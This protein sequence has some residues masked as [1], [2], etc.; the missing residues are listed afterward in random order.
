M[1][2]DPERIEDLLDFKKIEEAVKEHWEAIGLREL[3]H[4]E[5]SKNSPTGYVEGPPTLNGEPHLGH[6]RGRIMKGWDV[7]LSKWMYVS[8]S[9]EG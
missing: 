7:F 4:D 9:V 3:I 6:L 8:F 1:A 5:V 2:Q